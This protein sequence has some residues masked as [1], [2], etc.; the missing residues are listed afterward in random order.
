MRRLFLVSPIKPARTGTANYF[1][2]FLQQLVRA[3]PTELQL[4]VDAARYGGLP[5][6]PGYHVV[7]FRG[8]KR[9]PDDITMYFLANN[10]HHR[11]VH[12]ML[13]EHRPKDGIAVSVVHE[14]DMWMNIEAMCNLREYGFDESDLRYFAEYEF[15]QDTALMCRLNASGMV[16]PNFHYS[17][18]AGRHIYEH[19][20]VAVF[21]SYFA[22]A[23]F[24]LEKSPT[25]V[26]ERQTPFQSMVMA[27]PPEPEMTI[28][29]TGNEKDRFVVGTFGWVKKVKQIDAL[30]AAFN[31]FFA[32]LPAEQRSNVELRIV[33]HVDEEP[34]FYPMAHAAAS[35][36]ANNIRFFGY[37]P[38]EE[39]LPL[40]AESSLLFSLR[41]PSCGETS[42]PMYQARGLGIPVVLSDYAAFAEEEAAY[43]VSVKK[44]QQHSQLVDILH[45]EYKR[46]TNGRSAMSSPK[47]ITTHPP[48]LTVQQMLD[49][50]L[51]FADNR[52][53]NI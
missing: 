19:S 53:S 4:V 51:L 42:G 2:L 26:S 24:R 36:A 5:D 40:M 41:F 12:R 47:A 9:R 23:K 34:G 21:H 48:K 22:E 37:V 15:G 30:I 38:D 20:D 3:E 14:P 46:F 8:L 52:A 35:K 49:N 29:H 45:R 16:S 33:G 43:H 44:D 11:Y 7:D 6:K 18:L 25:Y 27:H 50:V 1:D 28:R 13:Y 17:S 39:L 10:D 32:E 31:D